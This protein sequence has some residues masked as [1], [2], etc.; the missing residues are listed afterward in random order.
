MLKIAKSFSPEMLKIAKSFSSEMLK[1]AKFGISAGADSAKIENNAACCRFASR[2]L[3][4]LHPQPTF[5]SK[6]C[7][8]NAIAPSPH[9][10]S[11]GGAL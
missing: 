10:N 4:L 5:P 2:F 9:N 8:K 6:S 3:L 1:I 7:G 11:G